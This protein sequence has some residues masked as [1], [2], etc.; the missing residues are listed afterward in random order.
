MSTA[1][2]VKHVY[3]FNEVQLAEELVDGVW[4]NVRALLG[5]QGC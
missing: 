4:E 1:A 5:G 3:L 2:D